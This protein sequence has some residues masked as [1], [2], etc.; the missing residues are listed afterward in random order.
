[1]VV[2]AVLKAIGGP[3]LSRKKLTAIYGHRRTAGAAA[4]PKCV[5]KVKAKRHHGLILP[6]CSSEDTWCPGPVR[7]DL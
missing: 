6:Q 1:M 2:K 3:T 7:P 5:V 4:S